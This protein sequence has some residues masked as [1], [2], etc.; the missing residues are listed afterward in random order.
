MTGLGRLAEP[1]NHANLKNAMT[2]LLSHRSFLGASLLI[3]VAGCGSLLGLDDFSDAPEGA[4][5]TSTT[6]GVGGGATT[7]TS[8]SN[9]GGGGSGQGGQGVGGA[10]G[11]GG[12]VGTCAPQGSAFDVFTA[13]D[14]G[15]TI[16]KD[17]IRVLS[18]NGDGFHVAVVRDM[19]RTLL[20]RTVR[21]GNLS[22]VASFTPAQ[23][24]RLRTGV[25]RGNIVD[26]FGAIDGVPGQVTFAKNGNDISTNAPTS[27]LF[28][29]PMSCASSVDRLSFALDGPSVYYAGTCTPG[30]NTKVLF[31]GDTVN[32]VEVELGLDD[33][34]ANLQRLVHV[35]GNYVMVTGHD[36]P[37]GVTWIRHGQDA[38]GLLT[39]HPLTIDPAYS[40]LVAG[41]S[42][43]PTGDGV[44]LAAATAN[45]NPFDATF[46][47]GPVTDYSNFDATPPPTLKAIATYNDPTKVGSQSELALGDDSYAFVRTAFT[48]TDINLTW[49]SV[50]GSPL[51]VD[52]PITTAPAMVN[53]HAADMAITQANLLMFVAW[54]ESVNGTY[55]VRAQRLI[56]GIT[57]N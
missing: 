40:S 32:N 2:S 38:A 48:E 39:V 50:D 10:G 25:D 55:S 30:D 12:L 6:S 33:I 46:W 28:G 54:I 35:G 14:L 34:Q 47:A 16:N 17:E 3:T 45:L 23:D 13:N 57:S 31:I 5:T 41:L 9:A 37:G 44:M 51:L 11:S 21:N 22:P 42:P 53:Y 27:A 56:C 24:F 18:G 15:G 52:Y 26:Y 43:L 7:S 36:G 19:P 1:P 8:S 29:T 20:V 4:S 49:F